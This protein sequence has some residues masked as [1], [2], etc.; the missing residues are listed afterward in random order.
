MT[1][2]GSRIFRTRSA[3]WR[4]WGRSAWVGIVRPRALGARSARWWSAR[5]GWSASCPAAWASGWPWAPY[6]SDRCWCRRWRHP[7]IKKTNSSKFGKCYILPFC[8][9][10]NRRCW[11]KW[12]FPPV[13]PAASSAGCSPSNTAGWDAP[14]CMKQRKKRIGGLVLAVQMDIFLIR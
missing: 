8:V 4:S 13:E 2:P 9:P 1:Y 7:E 6:P 3:S 10:G 11:A 5:K 12:K 14:R